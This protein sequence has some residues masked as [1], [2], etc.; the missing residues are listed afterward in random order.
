MKLYFMAIDSLKIP[1]AIM[2][3]IGS[4]FTLQESFILRWHLLFFLA[5]LNL[6]VHSLNTFYEQ[7]IF[8]GCPIKIC[9]KIV[10]RGNAVQ[11]F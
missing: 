2:T 3:Q 5:G 11:I 9:D 8:K 4:N 7:K 1:K 6:Q 10:A